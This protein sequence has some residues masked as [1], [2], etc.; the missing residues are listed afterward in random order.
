MIGQAAHLAVHDHQRRGVVIVI[1]EELIGQALD[2]HDE[3]VAVAVHQEADGFA[4][5][6]LFAVAGRD[7]HEFAGGLERLLDGGQH[8][9]EEWTVQLGYQ[10][11]DG[12][13]TARRQ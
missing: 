7:Q 11:P 10:H 3:R 6:L 5:L 2:V 8:R 1:D 13:G 12:I 4:L 9:A